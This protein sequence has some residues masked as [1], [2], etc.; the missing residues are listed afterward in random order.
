MIKNVNVAKLIFILCFMQN[1]MCITSNEGVERELSTMRNVP[2]VDA[3]ISYKECW[4]TVTLRYQGDLH[5]YK[6]EHIKP[7]PIYLNGKY[8]Y[9]EPLEV[10]RS[11][12]NEPNYLVPFCGRLCSVWRDISEKEY[13]EAKNRAKEYR[14]SQSGCIIN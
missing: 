1:F 8:R 5:E 9:I 11:V 13:Y 2:I 6:Y 10:Y 3:S 4:T 14:A 7:C 12:N